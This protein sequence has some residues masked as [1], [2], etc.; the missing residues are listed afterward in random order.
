MSGSGREAL[1]EVLEGSG[2]PPGGPRGDELPSRWSGRGREALPEVWKA[3]S[4]SPREIMRPSRRSGRGQEA[5]RGSERHREALPDIPEVGGLLG[6]LGC[7]GGVSKLSR[8]SRRGW[9][10]LP[11]VRECSGDPPEVR[12]G[13]GDTPVHLGGPLGGARGP[14]GGPGEVRKP[15]RKSGRC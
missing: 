5:L 13:S 9:K 8:R 2:G 4:E 3:L 1:L 14:P 15:F 12:E 7:P 11:K 10:A 6:P